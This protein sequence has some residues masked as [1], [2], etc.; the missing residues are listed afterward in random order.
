MIYTKNGLS[1]KLLAFVLSVTCVLAFTPFMAFPQNANAA[2]TSKLS[3]KASAA[4]IYVGKKATYKATTK[5]AANAKNTKWSSSNKAIAKVSKSAAAKISVKGIAPGKVTIKAK[6]G[7]KVVKKTLKVYKHIDKPTISGNAVV[8]QTLTVTTTGSATYQWYVTNKDGNETKI[9][10]ATSKTFTIAAANL[11]CTIHCVATGTG[12]YTKTASSDETA[13]V[14]GNVTLKSAEISNKTPLVGETMYASATYG[15][16][17]EADTDK[18]FCT[19]YTVDSTGAKTAIED[20]NFDYFMLITKDMLGKKIVCEVK[21]MGIYTGTVTTEATE[22]VAENDLWST[23][24]TDKGRYPLNYA[25]AGDTLYAGV[26]VNAQDGDFTFQWYK[27]DTALANASDT[28]YTIPSDAA[29]GAKYTVKATP[30]TGAGFGTTT[31]GSTSVYVTKDISKGTITLDNTK[32]T[33]DETVTAIVKDE[34]GNTLDTTMDA[35][36]DPVR[37][38]GDA[39][40]MWCLDDNSTPANLI[41]SD[42]KGTEVTGAAFNCNGTYY[43][44]DGKAITLAGHKIVPVAV[45]AYAYFVRTSSFGATFPGH[46]T[47]GNILGTATSAIMTKVDTCTIANTDAAAAG[48]HVGDTLTATA[49]D[50]AGKEIKDVT[51]QWYVNGVVV[52]GATNATYTIKAADA[53][54]TIY[55]VV[56]GTGNYTGTAK[57]GGKYIEADKVPASIKATDKAGSVISTA[58]V[59]DTLYATTTPAGAKDYVTYQWYKEATVGAKDPAKDTKVGTG[60][61]YAPS[62]IGTYYVE[63]TLT[64]DG[65]AIWKNGTTAFESG[66]VKVTAKIDSLALTIKDTATPTSAVTTNTYVGYTITAAPT[67][68]AAATGA[69]YKWYQDNTGTTSIGEGSS[70]TIKPADIGHKLVCKITG[71]TDGDYANATA[72]AKTSTNAVYDL[73]GVTVDTYR[74]QVGVATNNKTEPANVSAKDSQPVPKLITADIS[75]YVTYTWAVNGATVATNEDYAPVAADLCKALSYTITGDG[76]HVTGTATYTYE[77]GVIACANS[78][79]TVNGVDKTSYAEGDMMT[80][81]ITG[82]TAAI[83]ADMQKDVTITWYQYNGTTAGASVTDAY[84][85][86]TADS[87]A[88]TAIGTGTT[89]NVPAGAAGHTIF[90][91]ITPTNAYPSAAFDAVYAGIEGANIVD[92]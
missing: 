69:T 73:S 58:V 84:N 24:I 8:G 19:W 87:K 78:T 37:P 75:S 82:G 64:T 66:A 48:N 7:K 49:K 16:G 88:A 42:A 63:A 34:N 39:V 10:S 50:S 38:A 62:A 11:G 61:T 77:E 18:L 90:Y 9:K 74:P 25:H 13:A 47:C 30:K 53:G 6:N 46:Y 85:A 5:P 60:A 57:A 76:T 86:W 4:S 80:A 15:D 20:T 71:A 31:K 23:Y 26:N 67:P 21:G 54:S 45:G 44:E 52:S 32:P 35:A 79:F 83:D 40:V 43:N 3:V 65:Q 1:K 41:C 92:K 68:A 17:R 27:G 36:Y 33:S 29:A 2:S 72:V 70:Y 59:G 12:Y 56:T 91:V 22:A 28:T 89:C 51:Y 14:A 55:C 81:D